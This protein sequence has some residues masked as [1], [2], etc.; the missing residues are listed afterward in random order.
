MA[1]RGLR[2]GARSR[3]TPMC[4]A[5]FQSHSTSSAQRATFNVAR[6]PPGYESRAIRH[7]KRAQVVIGRLLLDQALRPNEQALF[8]GD[9]LLSQ[10]KKVT[11]PPGRNPGS[12]ASNVKSRRQNKTKNQD[13]QGRPSCTRQ[14]CC[15]AAPR[16]RRGSRWRCAAA[17]GG[18]CL[19]SASAC[20]VP[21]QVR[22]SL[23]V[24]SAP[25]ASRR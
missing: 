23:T 10:Q 20:T 16:P 6:V 25:A 1:L 11:R 24:T 4:R 17:A 15:R 18:A 22:K 14:P 7:H 2:G 9:F 12:N 3:S 21:C 19:S 5:T 13:Q 8:F